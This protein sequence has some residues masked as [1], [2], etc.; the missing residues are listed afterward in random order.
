MEL[1]RAKPRINASTC[2]D[3]SDVDET[4][5]EKVPAIEFRD[6]TFSY[7]NR[8]EIPVLRNLNLKINKGESIGIV[9][10]SGCGK[11][12]IIGLL[13]RFYDVQSGQILING[14]PIDA[15]DVCRHRSR[16]GLVS[17]D[18]MLYGATVRE[19]IQLGLSPDQA[20]EMKSQSG[21]V[22][23]EAV[24]RA[25]KLAHVDEF[26]SSLPDGYDTNIGNHGRS[27]SGGQRQRL[28]IARALIRD[29]DFV[30]F[31]EATS[32]LDTENEALV[33]EALQSLVM[34]NSSQTFISVAHRLSTIKNCDRIFVLHRGQVV[35]EG[36]HE[37][38]VGRRGQYYAM[39]QA[40]TLD[41]EA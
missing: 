6:V 35:E 17:Q 36:K 10:A 27:L 8:Q 5:D 30:L 39:V 20:G 1:C 28:A 37:D 33:Q 23:H 32:A 29:P 11:S 12:T 40:Q 25:C 13:E 3:G 31:D 4:P 7:P 21:E 9:G 2:S 15:V 16:L 22:A 34:G 41:K 14:K 24:V 18:T 26:V 38:L 19:N